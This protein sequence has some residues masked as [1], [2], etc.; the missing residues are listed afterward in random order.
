MLSLKN[1][2]MR[3]ACGTHGEEEINAALLKITGVASQE[4][5][6][7]GIPRFVAVH[8]KALCQERLPK[9][10]IFYLCSGRAKFETH[11]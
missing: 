8:T 5:I 10:K 11:P 6:M 9:R 3:W 2:R 1:F 7:Y 4:A